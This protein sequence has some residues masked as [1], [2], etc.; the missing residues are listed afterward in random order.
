VTSFAARPIAF[1]RVQ[2]AATAKFAWVPDNL[3][4]AGERSVWNVIGHAMVKGIHAARNS[5]GAR[6][7]YDLRPSTKTPRLVERELAYWD[8]A[9]LGV[10]AEAP[11]PP[12][13]LASP[14][15]RAL[16]GG[17]PIGLSVLSH[18]VLVQMMVLWTAGRPWLELG[19]T[20]G[21]L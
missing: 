18:S 4:R 1:L 20:T 2:L 9:R 14:A 7:L 6:Y 15:A 5:G 11:V 8:Q 3:R 21:T 17:A 12:M 19:P 10:P 13:G 16:L